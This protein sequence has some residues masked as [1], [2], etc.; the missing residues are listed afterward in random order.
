LS[1]HNPIS[2]IITPNAARH[3]EISVKLDIAL[4]AQGNQLQTVG[5]LAQRADE[6]GFAG[7]W[8]PETQH[9]PF[10]PL[11]LAA[12]HSD[13]LQLGTAVAI[14]FPRSPLVI[15]HT[16]WDLQALSNG[17]FILGLGTQVQAHIERRFSGVW[18]APVA[19]LRD[20]IGAVRAIWA[21]WQGDDKIDYQGNYYRHTLMMPFFNPGPIA[22]PHIPIF[23]AG[24]NR[25]M[26][27]LAGELCDGFHV[28]PFH[29]AAYLRDHLRPQIEAAATRAGRTIADIELSG[30]IFVITGADAEELE[31]ARAAA[32]SQ[33]A[34][35]ASTPSYRAVLAHHGWTRAGEQLSRFATTR[36]WDA[37]PALI[38]DEMLAIFAVEAPPDE[39]GAAVRE[40]YVGLLDRVTFYR[41]FIPDQNEAM[42]RAAIEVIQ[43]VG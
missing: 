42:W 35:Y 40:R 32:R 19:R 5:T 1:I 16:A 14:A 34:F 43:G 22:H 36:R 24:V 3:L 26:A 25:G 4:G 2:G 38:T 20:Y 29:S 41:P 23:I 12:T 15:A 13:H 33:I 18:D 9:D 10:L 6:L 17:R 27:A 30:S 31:R 28:H 8:A 21:S 37:M 11:T 7:L 39:I